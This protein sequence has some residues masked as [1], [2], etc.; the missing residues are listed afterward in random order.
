MSMISGNEESRGERD[1]R[2]STRLRGARSA[3]RRKDRSSEDIYNGLRDRDRSSEDMSRLALQLREEQATQKFN[4][5]LAK[6]GLYT[7]EIPPRFGGTIPSPRQSYDEPSRRPSSAGGQRDAL[8]RA[9]M[10]R[11][12]NPE[13]GSTV[14]GEGMNRPAPDINDAFFGPDRKPFQWTD[15]IDFLMNRPPG[16]ER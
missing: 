9:Y 15:I 1:R 2:E 5:A 13:M 4:D 14:P 10:A 12:E 6:S 16:G 11:S 8:I 3:S 7:N